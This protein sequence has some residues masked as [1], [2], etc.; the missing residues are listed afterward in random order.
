[1][2]NSSPFFSFYQFLCF[3]HLYK[4]RLPRWLGLGFGTNRT[5]PKTWTWRKSSHSAMLRVMK[6]LLFSAQNNKRNGNLK[7]SEAKILPLLGPGVALV[8]GIS[9][10]KTDLIGYV[11]N[12][13]ENSLVMLLDD[14]SLPCLIGAWHQMIKYF[15]GLAFILF[16]LN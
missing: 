6:R 5:G 2:R 10:W 16:P 13:L 11:A 4:L 3:P 9:H 1:M 12:S 14:G 7:I 15:Y 8:M